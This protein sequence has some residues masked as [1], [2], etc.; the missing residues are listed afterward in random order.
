MYSPSSELEL[1]SYLSIPVFFVPHCSLSYISGIDNWP[2]CGWLCSL[3]STAACVYDG[4]DQCLAHMQSEGHR[5]GTPHP[6]LRITTN[7]K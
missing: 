5:S 7:L 6:S 2:I 3:V 4:C 1:C